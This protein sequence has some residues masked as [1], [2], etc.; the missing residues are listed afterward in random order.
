MKKK[1]LYFTYINVARAHYYAEWGKLVVFKF[2]EKN[3][4]NYK[5]LERRFQV[6]TFKF[7]V[8][9]WS[10]KFSIQL[11]IGMPHIFTLVN[12]SSQFNIK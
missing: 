3:K 4:T 11:E 12:Y 1:T 2:S 5:P 8:A 10:E 6:V 9:N 7:F